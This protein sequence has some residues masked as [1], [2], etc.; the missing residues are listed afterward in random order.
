MSERLI[1]LLDR[2]K[3][4]IALGFVGLILII[5]GLVSGSFSAKPKAY[6]KESL[7]VPATPKPIKVD[8]SGA[9]QKPGVYDLKE[10]ARVEDAIT[11]GGGFLDRVN[12]E[13]VAKNLNLAS[14]LTD[15]TKLYIP[16]EGETV[17][18]NTGNSGSS[19]VGTSGMVNINTASDSELDS[20][21][22]IGQVT[23]AKIIQNR[24]YA[25]VEDLLNKKVVSK[26]VYD[27]IKDRITI[28]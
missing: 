27:K 7:A 2:F 20:L 4:P 16:F 6:P 21:P 22:G 12:Q 26:S 5:G 8:I 11:A 1:G 9:V 14:K 18:A 10:G 28:N 25:E 3:L 13:Y 24:P 19:G 15:G 23:A 17:S